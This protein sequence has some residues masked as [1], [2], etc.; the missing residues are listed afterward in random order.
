VQQT[1]AN[2]PETTGTLPPSRAAR[3]PSFASVPPRAPWQP[4]PYA[5]P[6]FLS[7]AECATI[8]ALADG[9]TMAH[10]RLAGGV[11]DGGIR[12]AR[13][14]W[15]DEETLPWLSARFVRTLSRIAATDFPFDFD[16]FEEG[17]LLLRY[18][19]AL[20]GGDYYD[21]HMDIG[22][23]GSTVSRKLTLIVQ[24]SDPVDYAGGA[25]EDNMAG[26]TQSSNREQ[27]TLT[28]SPSFALH[29]VTPV[30][31]GCR[32]ALAAWAHGPAFR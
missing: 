4:R 10:A 19:G 25:L 12:S 11:A 30:T 13:A 23:S 22:G 1:A 18:D 15:L 27:G 14:C 16:G 17:F 28:A 2:I 24:L 8:R 21:W 9:S 26:D 7:P 6:G 5:Q 29:R 20:A 31:A 3:Q 32:Y